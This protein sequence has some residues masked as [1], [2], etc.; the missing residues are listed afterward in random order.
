MTCDVSS[1]TL[2]LTHSFT[3]RCILY[4]RWWLWLCRIENFDRL[5]DLVR[6]VVR[7]FPLVKANVGKQCFDI[8][9]FH[10]LASQLFRIYFF[11]LTV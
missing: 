5:E 3:E 11:M 9:S 6:V 2:N 4:L 7:E 1:G 8:S 10:A